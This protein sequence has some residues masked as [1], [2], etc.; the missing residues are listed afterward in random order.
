[1]CN[2][3]YMLGVERRVTKDPLTG[4]THL[5]MIQPDYIS[6][7]Y[8]SWEQY[9]SKRA[10][11]TPVPEGTFLCQRDKFGDIIETSSDLLQDHCLAYHAEDRRTTV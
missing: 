8:K 10:V 1:M 2:P 5:E 9:I 4:A 6:T 3:K 11:H 7:M